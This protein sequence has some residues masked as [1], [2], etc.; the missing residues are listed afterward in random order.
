MAKET[1][2]NNE[3]EAKMAALDAAMAQIE[4]DFEKGRLCV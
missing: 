2:N 4:K 1:K 3:K